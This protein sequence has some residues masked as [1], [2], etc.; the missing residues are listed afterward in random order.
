ML[1]GQTYFEQIPVKL[2]LKIAKAD[3]QI[4]AVREKRKL[5]GGLSARTIRKDRVSND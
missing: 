1:K 4:K 5:A 2:V 3:P